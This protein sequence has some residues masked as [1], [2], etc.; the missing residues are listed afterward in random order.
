MLFKNKIIKS[1]TDY[2]RMSYKK[3]DLKDFAL[4]DCPFNYRCH[5]NAVQKVAEGNA[6]KV[7]LVIGIEDNYPVVHFINQLEDGS[8][9]D[10]TWGW[11]YKQKEYYLIREVSP[12]EYDTIWNVLG[13]AQRSLVHLHSN[14][15]ERWFLNLDEN[16]II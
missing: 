16:S 12:N 15:F 7:L 13:D 8:Y 9:Q 1:I 4:G 11:R 6:A 5:L 10:N 14:W 3:M 2:V